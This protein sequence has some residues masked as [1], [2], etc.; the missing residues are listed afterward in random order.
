ME[1]QV[2]RCILF[3]FADIIIYIKNMRLKV[4]TTQS[5]Q[6]MKERAYETLGS[7]IIYSPISYNRPPP[8]PL[9][10]IISYL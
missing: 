6:W 5:S 10:K 9:I 8:P 1:K 3:I 4:W 2:N 7:G